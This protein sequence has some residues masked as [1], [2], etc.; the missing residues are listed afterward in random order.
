MP[1]ALLLIAAFAALLYGHTLPF[2]F[3]FDD[4]VYLIDNPFAFD[5]HSLGCWFDARSFTTAP[6]RMQLDPDLAVNI[7]LRPFA[8]FTFYL[9]HLVGG[10]DPW[11]YRLVNV[12]LH[13]ANGF[14]VFLIFRHLFFN[15]ARRSAIPDSSALF[16][17]LAVAL[18]FVAHPLQIE[19]VTYII[20]RFTS[21]GGFFYLLTFWLHFRANLVEKRTGRWL[22]RCCSMAAMILGMLTKESVVTVPVMIILADWLVMGSAVRVAARRAL[23][24]LLC[25]GVVPMLVLFTTWA[26]NDGQLTLG[27][28]LNLANRD[29][30]PRQHYDYFLTSLKVIMSYLRLLL[31]PMNLNLDPKVEWSQSISDWRVLFSI[32]G[33]AGILTGAWMIFRRWTGDVRASMALVFTIWYFVTL[34][35]SSGLVP[36]PDAM[37]EHRSYVPT[38]GA[39]AVLVCILDMLRTRFCDHGIARL[40]PAAAAVIALAA[41][42]W[43]TL[44]RND[45]WR[46]NVSLWSDVVSK[47]P[48]KWRPLV[49]LGAA[50]AEEKG[51]LEEAEACFRK[52]LTMEPR[53]RH[54]HENLANVLINRKDYAGARDVCLKG[55]ALGIDSAEIHYNL[56]LALCGLGRIDDGVQK[57]GLALE[58]RPGFRPSHLLLGKVYAHLQRYDLALEHL[59]RAASIGPEDP[60]L[61]Q[62]IQQIERQGW[63]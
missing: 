53:A 46:S 32:A 30:V 47:S 15:S 5:P 58:R 39:I 17:P 48:T 55:I 6:A 54:M 22:L 44:A 31:V 25:M 38:I 61:T 43:A 16:V 62:A 9:N 8:Y 33:I 41:L 28:A 59:R 18:L 19:S 50:F 56:G 45:V 12:V 24:L 60:A 4:W 1:A 36:L 37:A 34:S 35:I 40:V 14:L 49:N 10:R 2:P 57:L 27:A 51:Q 52:V 20:Q 42:S 29:D 23:P 11:G 7:M 21:M 63:N 3:V 13:A 26:Q